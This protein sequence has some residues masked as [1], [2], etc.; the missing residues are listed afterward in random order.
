M[1][2]QKTLEKTKI[3]F[4][5]NTSLL[6]LRC[7]ERWLLETS[8]K[9]CSLDKEMR[10]LLISHNSGFTGTI[11]DHL[12]KRLIE[13]RRYLSMCD[14]NVLWDELFA[15]S[16]EN[17]K[18]LPKFIKRFLKHIGIVLPLDIK[19]FVS[20]TRNSHTYIVIGD[21][22]QAMYFSILVLISGVRS[23]TL[24]LH[25]RPPYKRFYMV[26]P[27]FKIL[28]KMGVLKGIH[29]VNIVDT[30]QL[31]NILK[32]PIHYIPNGVDCNKLR[33][34]SKRND[35]F[36][37]LFVGA[38]SEDKG[39]DTFINVAEI[40]K[41]KYDDVDFIIAS[42]GGLLKDLVIEAERGGII[43]FHGFVPDEVLAKL[44]AESHVA[45]LPS[46]DEA[47]GL[48]SLEAQASG[49]P[50][51]ATDIPA[52]RQSVVNG[53]T[54]ILVKPYKPEAF[55]EAVIKLRELWMFNRDRYVEMCVNARRN[56]ERFCWERIAKRIYKLISSSI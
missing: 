11:P 10:I 32:I 7:V 48:V 34:R 46:R 35:K 37:V 30:I 4:I 39:V 38:L 49:T 26:K 22:F 24:G 52:F 2:K 45:L 40:V 3:V 42:A 51:I 9:L 47:F 21:A 27:M 43:K 41:K 13:I 54:G 15:L 23:I 14:N 33:P 56:A 19:R 31:R 5:T 12:S 1:N 29:A 50:V 25:S 17:I 6:N 55:A 16:H 36:Q 20:F 44:Y 53:V 28:N 18:D 8:I